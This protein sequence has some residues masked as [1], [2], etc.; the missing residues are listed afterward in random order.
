A[1]ETAVAWRVALEHVNG[2]TSLILTRQSVPHIPRTAD[3]IDAVARGGYI[4]LAS[5]GE[6]E[7]IFIATGSEVGLAMSVARH[8]QQDGRRVRVVSMPCTEVFDRQPDEYRNHVLPA[9]DAR[10]LA[11][12]AGAA[13]SW[14]RYVDGKGDV[15]GIDR[16]GQSAPAAALFEDYGYTVEAITVVARRLLE[17]APGD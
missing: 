14:W 1:V 11:I 12:E 8:L 13:D 10:R 5:D 4:L 9:T 7:L 15:I 17:R 2:P 16:F 3:Q 6:P